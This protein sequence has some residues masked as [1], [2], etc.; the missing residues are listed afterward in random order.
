ME[1]KE[2]LHTVHGNVNW[3]SQYG[4]QYGSSSKSLKTEVHYDPAIPSLDM[5]P[6][7]MKTL[8][9][10]DT[11]TPLFITVLFTIAKN[12]DMEAT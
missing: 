6:K 3:C 4:K 7:N 2:S 11:C 5:F 12:Q 9:Q 8:T 1:K 10:K